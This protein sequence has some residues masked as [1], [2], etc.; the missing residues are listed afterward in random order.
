FRELVGTMNEGGRFVLSAPN[1]VNL[2]KRVTALFG[3]CKW[4][5]MKD[6]Y[7]PEEFRGH[8]REP[9]VSDLRYIAAD[10]GLG[11]A[12][13]IG[14]NWLGVQSGNAAIRTLSTV[15][16]PLMR[17]RPSLCSNLYLVGEKNGNS[18]A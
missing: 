17:L 1:C 8:V 4:S 16:D 13:I 14:R 11:H 18:A 7:E 6:W 12:R 10:L 3:R 9:D 5:S 2:R 15:L